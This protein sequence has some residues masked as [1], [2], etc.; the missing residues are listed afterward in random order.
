MS[1][2]KKLRFK[3][4]RAYWTFRVRKTAAVTNTALRVNG[5]SYVSSQT[6]LGNNVHFNGMRIIGKGKAIIGDNFHSGF[7][8]VIMTHYHNFDNGRAIPYDNTY[9]VKDVSIGDNVWFGINVTVLAGVTIGEGAIIQ[10]GSV[11]VSDIPPLGIA[12]GHPAK[13][14][15]HR[16]EAHY[17]KL[18]SE[19]KFF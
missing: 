10:A 11:V 6:Y 5:P 18:K 19:G 16:N 4:R 2:I 15:K 1:F 9:I 7:G 13:V 8:C 12:G 3:L 17:N 14:F